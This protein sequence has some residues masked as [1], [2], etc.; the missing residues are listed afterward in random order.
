MAKAQGLTMDDID[1]SYFNTIA[2]Q[3][4]NAIDYFGS[5]N[6]FVRT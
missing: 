4:H 5:V 3:A 1:F 6:D 2:E